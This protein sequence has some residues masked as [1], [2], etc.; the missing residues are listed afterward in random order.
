[1]IPMRAVEAMHWKL[2]QE[3]MA[4]RANPVHIGNEANTFE[5]M[6]DYGKAILWMSVQTKQTFSPSTAG[7]KR[8]A[9]SPE[10]YEGI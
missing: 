1:M 7:R 5:H 3:E 10:A 4:R 9:E 2:G 8:K 6:N